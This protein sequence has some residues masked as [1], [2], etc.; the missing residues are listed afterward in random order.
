[1]AKSKTKLISAITIPRISRNT[2]SLPRRLQHG[3]NLSIN[4]VTTTK[5][6]QSADESLH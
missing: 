6:K 5:T 1:M 4:P 2:Q 3:R